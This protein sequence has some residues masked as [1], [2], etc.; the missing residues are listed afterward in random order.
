M[1]GDAY[2]D[3]N[4]RKNRTL[5]KQINLLKNDDVRLLMEERKKLKQ[6][7]DKFDH[8][9][10]AFV[11]FRSATVTALKIFFGHRVGEPPRLQI[12]QWHEAVNG[13]WI[14]KEDLPDEF[15]EYSRLITY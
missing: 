13:E 12:Y 10:N 4:N 5:R 3:L 9:A 11:N 2:D 7:V 1:F 14:I 8:P 6:S 15:D